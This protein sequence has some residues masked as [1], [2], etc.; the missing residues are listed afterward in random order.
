MDKKIKLFTPSDDEL[1]GLDEL[2]S[3]IPELT[4]LIKES[5]YNIQVIQNGIKNLKS[6]ND[7]TKNMVIVFFN[8]LNTT[9]LAKETYRY[10]NFRNQELITRLM[11][12]RH[13]L[14]AIIKK[15]SEKHNDNSGITEMENMF[16]TMIIETKDNK[17][18]SNYMNKSIKDIKFKDDFKP[19]FNKL[20]INE[21]TKNELLSMKTDKKGT[22]FKNVE[23]IKI[24]NVPKGKD[25]VNGKIK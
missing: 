19:L 23:S 1:E 3:N 12:E 11:E 10:S 16:S 21:Y 14:A 18:I 7:E 25:I 5:S 15:Q 17:K 13:R 9:H 6:L 2:I 4:E 20:G 24:I 22:T 8:A